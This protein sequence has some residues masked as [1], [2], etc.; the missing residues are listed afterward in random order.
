M[1]SNDKQVENGIIVRNRARLVAQGYS[2]IEGIDLR[3]P[4]PP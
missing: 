1:I 3:K 4:L 2:Q